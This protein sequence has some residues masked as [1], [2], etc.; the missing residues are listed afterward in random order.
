[1]KTYV[2]LQGYHEETE[3]VLVTT[4]LDSAIK[5]YVEDSSSM[6]EVWANDKFLYC[7]GILLDD[8]KI[9]NKKILSDMRFMEEHNGLK[10]KK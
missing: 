3:I 7:Y 10:P 8:N 9:D 4:S 6:I 1:M 5:E 2:V